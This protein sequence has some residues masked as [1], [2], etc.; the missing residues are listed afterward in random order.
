MGWEAL[1]GVAGHL[2]IKV[3]S[4]LIQM[5]PSWK[6]LTVVI[7]YYVLHI[8]IC[9]IYA[10]VCSMHTLCVC[11]ITY[12]IRYYHYH[13]EFSCLKSEN[14]NSMGWY[15]NLNVA[16][17]K[18]GNF[19]GSLCQHGWIPLCTAKIALV[20][21]CFGVSTLVPRKSTSWPLGSMKEVGDSMMLGNLMTDVWYSL[22]DRDLEENQ[23]TQIGQKS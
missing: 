20:S 6:L 18:S 2:V 22:W 12:I 14:E 4:M 10:H 1:R 3:F 7:H 13:L 16:I 21:G 8:I 11:M 19:I 9:C 17:T 5:K 15:R 23:S